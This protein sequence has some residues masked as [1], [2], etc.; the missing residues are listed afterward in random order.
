M[1]SAIFIINKYKNRTFKY[2]YDRDDIRYIKYLI[3]NYRDY[4]TDDNQFTC[5]IN[6]LQFVKSRFIS[7]KI[8]NTNIEIIASITNLE[9][10]INKFVTSVVPVDS[11][12][13][14]II[15]VTTVEAKPHYLI[16]DTE[17]ASVFGYIVNNKYVKTTSAFD[18]IRLVQISWSVY[19]TDGK[20]VKID[21]HLIKP[22]N[23]KVTNTSIH[24]ISNSHAVKNGKPIIDVLNKFYDDLKTVKYVIAHN[25]KFDVDVVTNE[26]TRYKLLDVLQHFNTKTTIC[27]MHHTKNIVKAVDKNG[28]IKWPRLEELYFHLFKTE[29]TNQHN[30][31]YD[32]LNL[33]ATVNELI[34]QKLLILA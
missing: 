4:L 33:A 3:T 27:T 30:A 25:I 11:M 29:M 24:G 6:F 2:I 21:D 18:R 15:T 31:K 32:V 12:N 22:D 14:A 34:N 7:E 9:N 19:D 8:D 10:D 5:I 13:N 26:L 20:H 16:F 23:F 28:K 17:T 1:D